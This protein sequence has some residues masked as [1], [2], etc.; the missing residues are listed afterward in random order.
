MILLPDRVY[1]LPRR[2]SNRELER[3]AHLFRGDVVNVSAWKDM[4]KQGR[5]YRDYFCNANSYTITN[6]KPEAQGLQGSDGEIFLDLE[7]DLPKDL[8][9]RF[10]VVF[11]HTTLEHVYRVQKAFKNLC[12]MTRD[13]V[14]IVLPFLQQYHSSYGD[15]WRFTPLAVKTMC[16]ENGFSVVYQ[17]FNSQRKSSV[18]TFTIASRLAEKWKEQFN[19]HFTC[20]DRKGRGEEPYIGC[21]AL[22]NYGYRMKVWVRRLLELG[23]KVLQGRTRRGV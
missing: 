7:E 4:D 23:R 5:Y 14:I 19:Y 1:R 16:D 21:R 2:W 11:N 8:R 3:C 6:Y 22:S 10:D 17:S 18:Y 12:D 20:V 9:R 15:Y 13:V